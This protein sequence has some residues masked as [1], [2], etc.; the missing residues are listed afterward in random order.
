MQF[1]KAR[2][3]RKAGQA[4]CLGPM[5][6]IGPTKVENEEKGAQNTI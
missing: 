5:R 4:K 6:K 3:E 2:L 1:S